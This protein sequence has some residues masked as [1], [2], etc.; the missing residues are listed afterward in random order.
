MTNE[1]SGI[2]ADQA[3]LTGLLVV[4]FSVTLPGPFC[5]RQLRQLGA[6][7]VH[8]EP[9]G[10][11]PM[12][13][14]APSSFAAVSAGKES[15]RVDLKSDAGREQAL[16]LAGRAD[17]VVEGWRPGVAD[18]LGVDYAAVASVNPK[19]V[20]CSISGYGQTGALAARPGH[21]INYVAQAGAVDMMATDGLPVGDL[22]AAMNAALQ[23]V[24]ALRA[25]ERSGQGRYLDV[26]ITGSLR[27]WVL[28]VGGAD[29][30]PFFDVYQLP[31]YGK[32]ETADGRVLTLGIAHEEHFWR[33]LVMVL[34]RPEWGDVPLPDRRRRSPEMRHFI[35]ARIGEMSSADVTELL[36]SLDTCWAFA[37]AP[38]EEPTDGAPPSTLR[39]VPEAV[40]NGATRAARD[41][42][43]KDAV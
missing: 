2:P 24:S 39:P 4:D 12:R 7:V 11:D 17:V 6:R 20:Y 10:G 1:T 37:V 32:F 3:P 9:P 13:T 43:V 26:S 34:G 36:S 40:H 5:T 28:A 23:I 29:Y 41:R 42:P 14:F 19:V 16:S 21:D 15:L 22:S 35:A 25:A 31:H 18:R 27:E 8:V 33:N 38:G 30:E